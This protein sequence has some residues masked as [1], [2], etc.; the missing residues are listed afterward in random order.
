VVVPESSRSISMASQHTFIKLYQMILEDYLFKLN[1]DAGDL[2]GR[3][4]AVLWEAIFGLPNHG[5]L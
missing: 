5:T 3:I 1:L 2:I 4:V